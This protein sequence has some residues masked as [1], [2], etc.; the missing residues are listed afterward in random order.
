MPHNDNELSQSSRRPLQTSK[1]TDAVFK[2]KHLAY[3]G[4]SFEVNKQ[5]LMQH[6]DVTWKTLLSLR[7][8]SGLASCNLYLCHKPTRTRFPNKAHIAQVTINFVR[9]TMSNTTKQGENAGFAAADVAAGENTEA[10]CK[11]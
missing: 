7:A 4:N 9:L 6:T 8:L 11:V 1:A 5:Q 10:A 3:T 2:L